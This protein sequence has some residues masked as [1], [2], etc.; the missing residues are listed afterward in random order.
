MSVREELYGSSDSSNVA[1]DSSKGRK[2][3]MYKIFLKNR[4]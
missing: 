1:K 4:L 3:L 2:L